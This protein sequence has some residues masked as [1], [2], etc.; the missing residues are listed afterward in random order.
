MPCRQPSTLAPST[1]F[2]IMKHIQSASINAPSAGIAS[3]V[4]GHFQPLSTNV[5]IS[6]VQNTAFEK[7]KP[8]HKAKNGFAHA[9]AR[10]PRKSP[11]AADIAP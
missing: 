2:A 7:N 1:T 3:F 6:L 10:N 5:K 9:N 4:Y 11:S 8:P